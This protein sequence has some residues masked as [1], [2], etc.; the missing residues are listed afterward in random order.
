MIYL[1]RYWKIAVAALLIAAL[2]VQTWRLD[3]AQKKLAEQALA[4]NQF[5]LSLAD[6]RAKGIEEGA[7]L[8]REAQKKFDDAHAAIESARLASERRRASAAE[9]RA[10]RL[11]SML[12]AKEWGCLDVGLPEEVLNEFRQ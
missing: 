10:Q 9:A 3:H 7:R 4:Q 11:E 5:E 2:G 12:S 6:Q 1:L 8:Q